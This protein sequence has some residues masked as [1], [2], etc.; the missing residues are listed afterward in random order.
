MMRQ[1]PWQVVLAL[2]LALVL[3]LMPACALAQT[4]PSRGAARADTATLHRTLDSLA[5]GHRGIAGYTVHNIDTGE[6]LELRG[7]EPFPTASLVKVPVLVTL[8]DLVE[9]GQIAL[10]D[11]MTVLRIDKVAGSGQLQYLHDGLEITV[12]DAAWLM[13][14]VSDNTAT[15]LLLDKISLRSV[16]QKMEAL[17]LPRTKVHHKSFRRDNTSIAMDSS[18]KYGLGVTTPNEMARLFQ[19][20]ANG[21]AVSAHADSAMLDI[22]EHNTMNQMLQR[23]VDGVTVAHKDGEG[24]DVR[25]ECALY[26]LQ[27]RVVACV[28][29]KQ[30]QDKRW[31]IDNDAQVTMARMGLAIVSAW[32]RRAGTGRE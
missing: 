20:L 29:T 31:L 28:L 30:N 3:V 21:K 32:P 8:Y 12:R 14:T 27:S 19:L 24:D 2:V 6:R 23:H 10:D 1:R 4:A 9:K 25:T 18:V 16:W 5:R 22:L 7:D 17:G 15:N 26:R 13:S 11:R